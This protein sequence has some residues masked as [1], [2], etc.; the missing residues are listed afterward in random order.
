MAG[1]S[2]VAD[3]KRRHFFASVRFTPLTRRGSSVKNAASMMLT[4]LR[5]C[6]SPST[7]GWIFSI[8][9]TG[10]KK[11]VRHASQVLGVPSLG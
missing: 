2:K 10:L 3:A 8:T 4:Q 9:T 7:H 5:E 6:Y 11:A 1:R